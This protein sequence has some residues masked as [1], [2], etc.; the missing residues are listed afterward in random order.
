M[1]DSVSF[2][3]ADKSS[4]SCSNTQRL[5]SMDRKMSLALNP[6]KGYFATVVY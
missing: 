4:G 5:P 1:I 3:D 6:H 2:I